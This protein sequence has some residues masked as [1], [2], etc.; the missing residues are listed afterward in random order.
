M[1]LRVNNLFS[2]N[3]PP[4]ALSTA[5]QFRAPFDGDGNPQLLRALWPNELLH[6]QA[7]AQSSAPPLYT[8]PAVPSAS[9]D[10]LNAQADLRYRSQLDIV[11]CFGPVRA[12]GH[13]VI[14]VSHSAINLVSHLVT[15]QSGAPTPY[16]GSRERPKGLEKRLWKARQGHR[17]KG[18]GKGRTRELTKAKERVKEKGKGK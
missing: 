1:P 2:T 17:D 18:G 3:A 13:S 8:V 5:Y 7:P 6:G 16:Q 14:L 10:Q 15:N 12:T 4:F 9:D 11:Q